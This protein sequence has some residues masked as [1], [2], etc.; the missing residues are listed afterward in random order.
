MNSP[1]EDH[2]T[3]ARKVVRYLKGTLGQGILLDATSLLHITGWC[4]SDYASCP[5]TRRSLTGRMVQL[6]TFHGKQ[7]SRTRSLDVLLK[8]NI[9]PWL[10][11][12]KNFYGFVLFSTS[13][14]CLLK[15]L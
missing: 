10:R 11:L 12:L 13:L 4:D 8:L 7:T 6:G 1:R 14:I 2:W 9:G 5:L 15:D 3:A